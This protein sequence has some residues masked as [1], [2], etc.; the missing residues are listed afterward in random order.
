MT[1]AMNETDAAQTA[2]TLGEGTGL[3][4]LDRDLVGQLVAQAKAGGMKPTDEGGL[5]VELTKRVLESAL[6]GEMTDHMGRGRHESASGDPA[7]NRRNGHRSKSCP[8]GPAAPRSAATRW[9]PS[10]GP[11]WEST[12]SEPT[13]P[14]P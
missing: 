2:D 6:E 7:P 3:E 5:L 12:A 10:G 13:T 14:K 11:D 8:P 1:N 9:T 4:V